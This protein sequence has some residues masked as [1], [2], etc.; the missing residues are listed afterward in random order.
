MKHIKSIMKL[1]ND[2]VGRRSFMSKAALGSGALLAAGLVG[3]KTAIL[4]GLPAM[5]GGAAMAQNSQGQDSEGLDNTSGDTA[6]QIFTAALIAEDLATTFYYNGIITLAAGLAA[7]D[8]SYLKAAL[9]EEIDHANLLRHLLA[10]SSPSSDPV[11]TFYFPTGSFES[12]A[13]FLP[14]LDALENAFIG[15]YLRAVKEFAAMAADTKAGDRVQLSPSH[16][17]YKSTQLEYFAEVAASILGI[18]AEHRALGRVIADHNP[19]NNLCYE[20]TDGITNVF[21]GASSAVVAL[22]PFLSASSGKTGYS[23]AT[24]LAHA[25]SVEVACTGGPPAN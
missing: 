1:A 13:S 12:L 3:G 21:H 18:E 7:D 8:Q 20:Q 5:P 17:P 22:T 16:Q 23:F 6:L 14:L 10:G 4:Q 19:P 9:S 11:Q 24:A 25:G 2:S 15:A